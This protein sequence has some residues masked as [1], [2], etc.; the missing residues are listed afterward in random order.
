LLIEFGY[1]F[2]RN[3]EFTKDFFTLLGLQFKTV[4][5]RGIFGLMDGAGLPD[6]IFNSSLAGILSGVSMYFYGGISFKRDKIPKEAYQKKLMMDSIKAGAVGS[7]NFF[8][9]EN[10]QFLINTRWKKPLLSFLK[11]HNSLNFLLYLYDDKDQDFM[12]INLMPVILIMSPFAF[13]LVQNDFALLEPVERLFNYFHEPNGVWGGAINA[14][15]CLILASF[16]LSMPSLFL[17]SY[18]INTTTTPKHI[19]NLVKIA[20]SNE[21]KEEKRLL[22]DNEDKQKPVSKNSFLFFSGLALCVGGIGY[23]AYRNKEKIFE[24]INMDFEGSSK[25]PQLSCR[26]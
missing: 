23:I 17:S 18:F 1:L 3:S 13:L 19:I 12:P 9:N 25:L 10:L 11:S 8:V 16:S 26:N 14:I 21:E 7:L 5:K 6:I 15:F 24:S 2:F 22:N 20:K 4:P